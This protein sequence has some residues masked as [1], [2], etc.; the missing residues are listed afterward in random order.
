MITLFR[1]NWQVREEWMEWSKQ[2]TNEELLQRRTGGIGN[3]LYTL[4]HI[5]D[6]E[7]S[8]V[9]ALQGEADEQIDMKDYHSIDQVKYLSD[10]Y[11]EKIEKF[12]QDWSIEREN[13]R[14]KVS[15]DP[16]SYTHGEVLRHIIAHEIHHIG[17]LSIWARE[18]GLQPVSPSLIGRK[19][20]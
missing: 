8:W 19:L 9:R 2:L 13:E 12:L 1:Y 11:H 18:V 4:V 15:W 16:V 6:V 3:I 10:K 17:Q 14:V 7:Y 5:I 20:R